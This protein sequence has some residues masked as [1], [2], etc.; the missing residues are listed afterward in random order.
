MS[1]YNPSRISHNLVRHHERGITVGFQEHIIVT[2]Q[3]LQDL[4]PVYWWDTVVIHEWSVVYAHLIYR[5]LAVN[6]VRLNANS[7]PSERAIAFY[8]LIH[9]SK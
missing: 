7:K 1:I 4:E 3:E 9:A 8:R 5:A 6:G 2:W